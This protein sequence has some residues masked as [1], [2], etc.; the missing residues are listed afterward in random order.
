MITGIAVDTMV[1]SNAESRKHDH[2]ADY[3][4]PSFGVGEMR[5][6][7][8]SNPVIGALSQ[9]AY[10]AARIFESFRSRSSAFSH[11]MK[12]AGNFEM[13]QRTAREITQLSLRRGLTRA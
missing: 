9:R 1:W 10:P 12:R 8:D 4:Y 6:R 5:C 13:R 7:Q 3:R 2:D 11:E